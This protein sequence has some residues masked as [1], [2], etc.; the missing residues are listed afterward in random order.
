MD[1]IITILKSALNVLA[2]IAPDFNPLKGHLASDNITGSSR[3]YEEIKDMEDVLNLVTVAT[4][5]EMFPAWGGA[6][7]FAVHTAAP[8]GLQA[9][10]APVEGAE[11]EVKTW[12]GCIQAFGPVTE[13]TAVSNVFTIILTPEDTADGKRFALASVYPGTPDP[14]PNRDGL[15]EGQQLTAADVRARNLRPKQA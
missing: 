15:A 12:H 2:T 9:W 1:N 3:F 8:C 5:I 4:S 10:A 6:V 14:E 7:G 11:Y 13:E